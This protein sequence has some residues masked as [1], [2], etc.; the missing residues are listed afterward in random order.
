MICKNQFY[1]IL[2]Q[3]ASFPYL[4]PYRL[5][6][7]WNFSPTYLEGAKLRKAAINLG[8]STQFYNKTYPLGLQTQLNSKDAKQM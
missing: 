8:N 3:K 2:C 6:C 4:V 1:S 5:P 7:W